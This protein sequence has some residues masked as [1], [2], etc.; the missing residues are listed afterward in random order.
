MRR[1]LMGLLLLL[2]LVLPF[3][4]FAQ[5]QELGWELGE[6]SF[7]D[8][9]DIGF[10]FYYPVGWV[11]GS[12]SGGIS[13]AETQADLDAQLD[14]DDTTVPEGRVMSILGIPLESLPADEPQ[15]MDD[16]ADFVVEVGEITETER[17]ELPIMSRRSISV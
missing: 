3:S 7:I 4:T 10:R 8:I 16:Y 13:I 2:L 9:T 1:F 12:S 15:S 6:D 17:I 14:D 5:D 11:W